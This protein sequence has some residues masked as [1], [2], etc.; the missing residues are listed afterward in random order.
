MKPIGPLMHEHRLIERMIKLMKLKLDEAIQT[1]SLDSDFIDSAVDFIR[2][3]ADR[4]HHG[5]EEGIL[6]RDLAQKQLSDVHARIMN[7]LLS[8]HTHARNIVRQLVD[9]KERYQRGDA[10]AVDEAAACMKELVEFYPVHILKE[11]K[12]FFFP[13]LDYFTQDEQDKMLQEFWE[14]DRK[15]IHEK[16]RLVVEKFEAI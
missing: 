2:T 6:F 5:K 11:D 4:C 10:K 15:L 16:Y 8:E 1:N 7:E 12:Q 9:A 14:F 13:I 3:Y